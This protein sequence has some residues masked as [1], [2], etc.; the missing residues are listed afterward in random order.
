[1]KILITGG[2]GFIGKWVVEKLPADA[3]IIIIDSLDEQV[4]KTL[5][6]F[7]PEIKERAL[8]I[9]DDIQNIEVHKE[10]IEGAEVVIHLA[11]QTGT[12]QSMYEINKY[13]QHNVS[14]T[15]KLLELIS[16]LE[17]KPKR[18]ILSSSRAVY[19][20]GAY[21]DGTSKYY[22]KGR[23]LSDLQKGNW[24]IYNDKNQELKSLN[25][26]EDQITNPTSVYGLTKLWQEQLLQNYCESQNIDLVT[27]RFQNVF[28]PKQELGNPYTGIIGIFTN[29]I[30]Q[31]GSVELFEDGL[32]TR[33]FIFVGDVAEAVCR[34]ISYTGRISSAINIGSGEATTL[35]ELVEA[36][37]QIAE[38]IVDVKFSGRFRVG[39][40]RHAVSDMT[41]YKLKFGEW[42]PMS[43]VDGLTQYLNWYMMQ[44]PVSKIELQLS[45][46][47]ME[48]KGLL[49][50][51]KNI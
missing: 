13:I 49:F 45:L 47:E 39:D 17:N 37:A 36:I 7:A 26:Q 28:G 34:C 33:D 42:K 3:E 23:I 1:M 44:S 31:E 43:L 14:G 20:E 50:N 19:G 16:G 8:C 24:E 21:I 15:A 29:A 18:I 2:A 22:P 48:E 32:M 38:K 30:L 9:K 51:S 40:V 12:G 5:R 27:L 46:Q 4:H 10:H 11:A 6:D 35:K 25:M 41:T